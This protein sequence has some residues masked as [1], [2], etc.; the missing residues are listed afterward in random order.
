MLSK[1]QRFIESYDL[2][3]SGDCVICAVS[4][5][6]DSVALLY[7][8]YLLKDKL[9]LQVKAAHFNHH[10]R[11]DESDAD[12]NFVRTLCQ[13]LNI[14]LFVGGGHVTPGKK[15]IEAAARDARYS[16]LNTLEGKLATAHTANDNAETVLM[17]MLRG[18]GLKGLGGIPPI[19]GRLIRP[20]LS[21]TRQEV[22]EFLECHE[23]C[24]VCDSS[25]ESDA[26]LRNRLRHHVI[27]LLQRENP[28]LAENMSNMALRLR[29]DEQMLAQLAA[30]DVLP[31]VPTLRA[32]PAAVRGRVLANFLQQCGICE[33]EAEHIR[34]VER[35]VYS[36]N[37][38]ACVTLQQGV[39]V[40]RVY[41]TL[42]KRQP[43][44]SLETVTLDCPGTM[45]LAQIG[46]RLTCVPA[47][48]LRNEKD[49]FTVIPK[50]TVVLRSRQPG[51]TMRTTGGTKEL[52]KL[53]ID[54]KIP[55]GSRSVIPVIADEGGVLGVYGI[56]VN[57]DR[58]AFDDT[59][60]QIC[61]EKI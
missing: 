60:V 36:G 44:E 56:G 30:Y 28:R 39:T 47:T 54:R 32:M 51:D 33:P 22:L 5:G 4:G 19:S 34:Q 12:E 49:C 31:D 11:G 55:A 1:L 35:I 43:L 61:F 6:A 10:L 20:M 58:L 37:P 46:L 53:F 25:N 41:D 50:G 24:H 13:R 40:E 52:K 15:G 23:L 2:L 29:Q 45:D 38:S 8:M 18:S 48:A 3:Q 26:F 17:H 21:I 57:I 42:R 27:P 9:R 14:P 16:F 59:A 7:A